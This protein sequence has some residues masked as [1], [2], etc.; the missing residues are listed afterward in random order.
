MLLTR[1]SPLLLFLQPLEMSLAGA[2]DRSVFF[3]NDSGGQNIS[4]LSIKHVAWRVKK[5]KVTLPII[6]PYLPYI[7]YSLSEC[8]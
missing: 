3:E 2:N 5:A 6:L 4:F 1:L 8:D 7:R